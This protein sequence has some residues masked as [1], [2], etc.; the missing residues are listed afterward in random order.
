M[1]SAIRMNQCGKTYK[2]LIHFVCLEKQKYLV[3][4]FLKFISSNFF[5]HLETAAIEVQQSK[6]LIDDIFDTCNTFCQ[7]FGNLRFEGFSA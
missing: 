2:M 4:L 6:S 1:V 5:K 3:L 7:L